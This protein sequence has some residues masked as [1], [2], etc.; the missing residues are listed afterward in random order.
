MTA[1]ESCSC[2]YLYVL[3]DITLHGLCHE[4]DIMI[5]AVVHEGI[6]KHKECVSLELQVCLDQLVES[7]SKV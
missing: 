5:R 3:H 1:I 4:E 7:V 2:P 6:L